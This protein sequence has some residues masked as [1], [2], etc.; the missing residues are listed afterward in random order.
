M[1]TV[2]HYA[3]RLYNQSLET[4]SM[5]EATILASKFLFTVSLCTR[6]A[7]GIQIITHE[8]YTCQLPCTRFKGD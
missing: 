1:G 8:L 7:W 6:G 3:V 4:E 5:V 2:S